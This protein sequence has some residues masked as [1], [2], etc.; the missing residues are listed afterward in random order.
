MKRQTRIGVEYRLPIRRYGS[1]P[2]FPKNRGGRQAEPVALSFEIMMRNEHLPEFLRTLHQQDISDSEDVSVEGLA[3]LMRRQ[4]IQIHRN[5]AIQIVHGPVRTRQRYPA[6]GRYD[7]RAVAERL[8]RS[9]ACIVPI[10]G[11]RSRL[12]TMQDRSQS[13]DGSECASARRKSLPIA[14]RRERR[15]WEGRPPTVFEADNPHYRRRRVGQAVLVVVRLN[16]HAL[17]AR[18]QRNKIEIRSRRNEGQE[19][20]LSPLHVACRPNEQRSALE[21]HLPPEADAHHVSRRIRA[22]RLN[23]DCAGG[24]GGKF[25]GRRRNRGR[26]N[27]LPFRVDRGGSNLVFQPAHRRPSVRNDI[28]RGC[29][30]VFAPIEGFDAVPQPSGDLIACR[31]VDRAPRNGD[32]PVGDGCSDAGGSG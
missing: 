23:F 13:V 14:T 26:P 8:D 1:R 27:G 12:Y 5:A 21:R 24:R 20:A 22:G 32:L 31:A 18:G 30:L 3:V 16:L 28:G 25:R 29:R 19:F 9:S 17:P 10:D 2:R 15:A 4:S 11:D 7:E 6:P